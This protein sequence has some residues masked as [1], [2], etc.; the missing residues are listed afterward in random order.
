[1][2]DRELGDVVKRVQ[3]V[4]LRQ[5]SRGILPLQRDHQEELELL[6]AGV[7]D[8]LI[9]GRHVTNPVGFR[10]ETL[11]VAVCNVVASSRY[12][13]TVEAM[14]EELGLGLSATASGWQALAYTVVE[15]QAICLDVGGTS[16]DVMLARNGKAWRTSSIPM[17]GRDFTKHLAETFNLPWKEAESLKLAYGHGRMDSS[18]EARIR[19]AVWQP[20]GAW[21]GAL[22]HTLSRMCG[23]D[24][25]PHQFVLCGGGS[26]LPGIVDA[27]RSHRWMEKLDFRRH[28]EV[29]LMRPGDVD[30]VLDLTG[31]LK[32]QEHVASMAVASYAIADTSEGGY[33]A[34]LSRA[35]KRPPVLGRGGWA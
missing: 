20:V 34:A 10:G 30:G 21:V 9:D 6:E 4:A 7:A 32:G 13:R 18:A 15:K 25:L 26:S 29:R 1:V 28:P 12:L 33:L 2:T 35:D 23:N 22:E 31:Q 17:G 19:A 24:T 27:M 14:T 11:T 16:T 3:R 5:L 8:I